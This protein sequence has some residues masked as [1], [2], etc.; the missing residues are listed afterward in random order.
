MIR[1]EGTIVTAHEEAAC[2]AAALRPDN[3]SLM[4]TSADGGAVRTDI[5]GTRLRS[6]IASVDD[7]LMNLAIAEDVCSYVS[8]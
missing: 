5:A 4:R 3:L 1:I 2:V 6:V 7:Y 8:R